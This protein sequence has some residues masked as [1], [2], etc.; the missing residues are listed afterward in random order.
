[1]LRSYAVTAIIIQG[2]LVSYGKEFVNLVGRR[3]NA[4]LFQRIVT[5]TER[6]NTVKPRIQYNTG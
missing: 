2:K 3:A 6:K 5:L 1:M 4:G